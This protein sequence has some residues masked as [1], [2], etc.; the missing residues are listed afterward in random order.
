LEKVI[1][2]KIKVPRV[3]IVKSSAF[4]ERLAEEDG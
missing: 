1:A 2:R 3:T 4:L